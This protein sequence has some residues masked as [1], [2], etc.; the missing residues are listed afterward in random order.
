MDNQKAGGNMGATGTPE[1][2]GA[3]TES[4]ERPE[5]TKN[6]LEFSTK[7]NKNR[8]TSWMFERPERSKETKASL[9]G[10][11][12]TAELLETSKST[13]EFPDILNTLENPPEILPDNLELPPD[14][15]PA[16]PFRP[17]AVD[18][19]TEGKIDKSKI[20]SF[21]GDII[22]KDSQKQ[23]EK[24]IRENADNPFELDNLRNQMMADGLRDNYGRIFGNSNDE[25][26]DT[27]PQIAQKTVA[28]EIATDNTMDFNDLAGE[29]AV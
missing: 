27:A 13:P 17:L 11:T 25:S 12:G 26:P 28:P 4:I 5:N 6:S 19:S 10:I 15:L 18:G 7:N 1:L 16:E 8:D 9:G 2:F 24:V 20:L 29:Q 23:V 22:D 3:N 21:D 14:T